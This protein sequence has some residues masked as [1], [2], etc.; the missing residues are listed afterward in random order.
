MHIITT[1]LTIAEQVCTNMGMQRTVQ[2]VGGESWLSVHFLENEQSGEFTNSSTCQIHADRPECAEC[3]CQECCVCV[4]E[5]CANVQLSRTVRS[6]RSYIFTTA[7]CTIR[8]RGR[9]DHLKETLCVC[10]NYIHYLFMK[11]IQILGQ[12]SNL[13]AN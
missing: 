2:V 11:P 7:G 12:V 10:F 13:K 6:V 3:R 5:R 8:G 1:P 4:R 9:V